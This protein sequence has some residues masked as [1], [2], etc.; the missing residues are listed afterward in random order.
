MVFAKITDWVTGEPRPRWRRNKNLTTIRGVV[1]RSG[2]RLVGL[3]RS[4]ERA[5][6]P[7]YEIQNAPRLAN[8]GHAPKVGSKIE[9]QIEAWFKTAKYE[10]GGYS[11]IGKDPRRKEARVFCG[12]MV[13][14]GLR[15]VDS[16]AP[17]ANG[18]VGTR[19]D[20]VVENSSGKLLLI[21]LKTGHNYGLRDIQGQVVGFPGFQN[22]REQHCFFQLLWTWAAIKKRGIETEPWLVM[23]NKTAKD[24]FGTKDTVLQIAHKI[25]SGI[26]GKLVRPLPKRHRGL[27]EKILKTI[28]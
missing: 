19:L 28:R 22:H 10:N 3:K 16:Q 9:D 4:L 13:A 12:L 8:F 1:H 26:G 15:R 14:L 6:W 18:S 5:L 21:E 17:E 24:K 25:R 27:C 23:I 11:K 7:D 2:T 20:W